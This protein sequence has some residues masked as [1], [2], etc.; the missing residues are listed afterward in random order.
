M[1]ANTMQKETLRMRFKG[2][3]IN[4]FA[5]DQSLSDLL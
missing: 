5:R 2:N 1:F 3:K 4:C